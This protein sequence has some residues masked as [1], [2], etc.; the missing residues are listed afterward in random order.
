MGTVAIG[1]EGGFSNTFPLINPTVGSALFHL[2]HALRKHPQP[3]F[4]G[5]HVSIVVVVCVC[6]YTTYY[7]WRTMVLKQTS[8][9]LLQKSLICPRV[10]P[11]LQRAPRKM[12]TGL[13]Q[14]HLR[15]SQLPGKVALKV[16]EREGQTVG[17]EGQ[18]SRQDQGQLHLVHSFVVSL[19]GQPEPPVL[20]EIQTIHLPTRKTDDRNDREVVKGLHAGKEEE[21]EISDQGENL[22]ISYRDPGYIYSPS[23]S[24][25]GI[26]Q[27]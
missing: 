2:S 9:G 15:R 12:H 23:V 14:L 7:V 24:W 18:A 17:E 10:R 6:V 20:A 5:D 4:S 13:Q 21:V 27:P 16:W 25:P 22:R 26:G 11:Y 19:P 1:P 8:H 3:F